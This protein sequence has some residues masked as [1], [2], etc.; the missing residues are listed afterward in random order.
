VG[1]GSSGVASE[2]LL[3]K[4]ADNKADETDWRTPLVDYLR[5]LSVRKDK[6]VRRTAFKYVL[7]GNELY[8]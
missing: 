6:N 1:S 3:V 8:R 7:M 2:I 5:N 4:S